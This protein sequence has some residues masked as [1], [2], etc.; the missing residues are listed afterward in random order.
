[1]P[2]WTHVRIAWP[3]MAALVLVTELCAAQAIRG[4]QPA[5][6]RREQPSDLNSLLHRMERAA[7][8]NRKNFRAYIVKRDYRFYHEDRD[9]L[10]SEVIAEIAFIPPGRKEFKILASRGH[11]RGEK[12]VRQILE[13][14]QKAA[15]AP[16]PPGAINQT[17]YYFSSLGRGVVDGVSCYL[18][19]I[20]PKR[21]DRN[22]VDGRIWVDPSTYMVRKIE[23]EMAKLPSWWLKSVHVK[24]DFN[25]VNSMWIETSKEAEANVRIFGE[26]IFTE[27]A[28][29]HAI[30]EALAWD[31]FPG[32]AAT[33]AR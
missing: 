8:Q 21:K 5:A 20:S 26:Y 23:G 29:D 7:L 4:Q 16:V 3:V 33:A 9:N 28:T 1:M 27:R 14:E 18:L 30:G 13:D 17:N 19:R 24:I 2:S 11:S 31:D 22:L 15:A 25:N 10:K 12:V 6:P 32:L